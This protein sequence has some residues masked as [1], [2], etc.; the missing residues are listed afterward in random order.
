MKILIDNREPPEVI[1]KIKTYFVNDTIEVVSLTCGD[2]WIDDI[3]IERKTVNDLLA[4][5]AD[6]RLLN[7]ASEMRGLSEWCYVIIESPLIW[8]NQKMVGTDW[9]FRSVQGALL[10]VQELGVCIAYCDDSNDFPKAVEWLLKRD[11]NKIVN[12]PPRKFGLPQTV[13]EKIISAIPGIGHDRASKLLM[14]FGDIMSVL[15]CLTDDK[16]ALPKS[17]GPKIRK[18]TQEAFG[19]NNERIGR[20]KNE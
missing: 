4:S 11:R 8:Y 20:I 3:I 10:Q 6:G 7:Q 16:C 14:E 15:E 17:I 5:I 9:H 13:G 12:L 18:A 19:L 2:V 1:S